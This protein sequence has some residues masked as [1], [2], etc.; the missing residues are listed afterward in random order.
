MNSSTISDADVRR[1]LDPKHLIAAM[2][3]A[4]R[5][6]Y[7]RVA[8]PLRMNFQTAAGTYL[9][10]PYQESGQLGVKFVLVRDKGS[11]LAL[12]TIR[13]TYILFDP[14]TLQPRLVM[15]ADALTEL[16]T[17]AHLRRRNKISGSRRQPGTR[18]S[19]NRETSN[20]AR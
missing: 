17:A 8:M 18:D 7:H 16:R 19:W 20:G 4:F 6:R 2:E 10:M 11:E 5:V 9:I 1:L 15:P 3:E 13:S 14:M 12:P